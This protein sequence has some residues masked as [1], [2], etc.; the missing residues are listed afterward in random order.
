MQTTPRSANTIAPA[1]NVLYPVYLSATIAAVSPTPL[2]PD[3]VVPT[4][5]STVDKT[6]LS[7]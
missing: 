4:D 7:I 2:A 1:Y 5:I 3:P 6:H